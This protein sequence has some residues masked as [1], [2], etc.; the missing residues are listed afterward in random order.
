MAIAQSNQVDELPRSTPVGPHRS[1]KSALDRGIKPPVHHRGG[2]EHVARIL[3]GHPPLRPRSCADGFRTAANSP[4]A[5]SA[6]P[7][8]SLR[9]V[10]LLSALSLITGVFPQ[11][12]CCTSGQ[13]SRS[14]PLSVRSRSP[15]PLIASTLGLARHRLRTI[16]RASTSPSTGC[17]HHLSRTPPG[18]PVPNGQSRRLSRSHLGCISDTL[19]TN[20]RKFRAH[21]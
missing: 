1:M 20:V 4:S 10:A 18:G 12:A 13:P 5:R 19:S 7:R 8:C 15:S 16:Y 6:M 9:C 3:L 11:S 14:S 2:P 21:G 17:D